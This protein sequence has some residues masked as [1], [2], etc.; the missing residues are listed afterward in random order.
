MFVAIYSASLNFLFLLKFKFDLLLF[1]VSNCKLE[2]LEFFP[3]P[4]IPDIYSIGGCVCP[5]ISIDYETEARSICQA[6][7]ACACPRVFSYLMV[8]CA[9]TVN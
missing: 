4:D 3:T 5:S 6:K 7:D 8:E 2:R 1:F 9:V